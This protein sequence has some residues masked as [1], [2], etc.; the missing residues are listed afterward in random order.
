MM[1]F[2]RFVL[3]QLNFIKE[4]DEDKKM[5]QTIVVGSINEYNQ[6]MSLLQTAHLQERVLG[7][8]AIEMKTTMLLES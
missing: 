6:A 5:Q 3:K 8:V 2:Y 4:T 7:R 1:I